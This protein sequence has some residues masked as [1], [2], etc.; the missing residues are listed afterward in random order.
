MTDCEA[1]AK[2]RARYRSRA[3]RSREMPVRPWWRHDVR[4]SEHAVVGAG[5]PVKPADPSRGA[6]SKLEAWCWML[7]RAAWKPNSV[8]LG[9]VFYELST[10][11][12]VGGTAYLAGIWNW[13]ESTVL[14]FLKKLRSHCMVT[15]G[16]PQNRRQARTI[17]ICNYAKFHVVRE[18]KHQTKPQSKNRTC[19]RQ[20][21]YKP[22][23]SYQDYKTKLGWPTAAPSL[24]CDLKASPKEGLPPL[25]VEA[26][27]DPDTVLLYRLGDPGYPAALL[28]VSGDALARALKQRWVKAK[29]S[30]VA[31]L[32]ADGVAMLPMP[33]KAPEPVSLIVDIPM[34]PP[35]KASVALV[36]LVQLDLPI[37]PVMAPNVTDATSASADPAVAPYA[38]RANFLKR[39]KG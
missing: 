19:N 3:M 15:W 22:Q 39:R 25:A 26:E 20:T 10:G 37:L 23:Q 30:N 33:D 38:L 4:M 14:E 24:V 13:T 7:G 16:R 35:V 11:Q 6:W 8:R 34:P 12:F 29:Q 31:A 9:G 32:M 5:Q 1:K 36:G 28:T 27:A 21:A 2:L 17:T 18:Q